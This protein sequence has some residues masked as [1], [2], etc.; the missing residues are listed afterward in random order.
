MIKD[1]YFLGS[2]DM[3]ITKPGSKYVT[4]E[5]GVN[6]LKFSVIQEANAQ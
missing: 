4:P 2:E 1:M 6:Q 3:K 5:V